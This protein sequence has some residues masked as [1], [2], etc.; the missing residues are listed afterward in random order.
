M[1]IYISGHRGV[2]SGFMCFVS[3]VAAVPDNEWIYTH[4]YIRAQGRCIRV[5]VSVSCVA[6]VPDSE[7]IP[8]FLIVNGYIY[9][10]PCTGAYVASGLMCLSVAWP[11]CLIVNG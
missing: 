5:H 2:A 11:L 3:C 4:N 8:L 6:A 10:Y 7:R 9:L 1:N